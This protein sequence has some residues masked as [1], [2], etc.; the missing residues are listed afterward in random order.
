MQWIKQHFILS[1]A[2]IAVVVFVLWYF[3]SS[4]APAAPILATTT[5]NSGSPSA[6]SSDQNL[7]ATLLQLRA[8]TLSGTI[9]QDPA[10]TSLLDFSTT[11]VP[12]PVGR[13]DPFAPIGHATST[14]PDSPHASQLFR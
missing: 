6:D 4:S 7:V 3:M 13:P 8:V 10:F 11:I 5:S 9:F 1:L 14:P 2:L 12:E